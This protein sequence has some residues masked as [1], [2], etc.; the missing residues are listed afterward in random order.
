MATTALFTD[1]DLNALPDISGVTAG[2]A[3]AVEAVVWGWLRPILNVTERPDP[4]SPELFSWAL[5]LGAIFRTNPAGLTEKQLGPFQEQYSSE[6]R[7]EIL[8]TAAGGG[9]TAPGAP[10]APIGSFPSARA[11]PDPAERC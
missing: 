9:T 4:V 1:A 3:T 8:R 5:E 10:L 2:E 7:D 11:Y 6:R